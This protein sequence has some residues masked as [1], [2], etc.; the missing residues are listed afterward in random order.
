MAQ[1][2]EREPIP[3]RSSLAAFSALWR[4]HRRA[5]LDV[6][7]RLAQTEELEGHGHQY[8][9]LERRGYG[10]DTNGDLARRKV[11]CGRKARG[12]SQPGLSRVRGQQRRSR[13]DEISPAESRCL[14]GREEP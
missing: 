10:Q 3:A 4:R 1:H 7:E 9:Q 11:A 6:P 13:T 2:D 8:W 14:R 12:H 5:C